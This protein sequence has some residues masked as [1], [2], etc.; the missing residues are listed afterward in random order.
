MLGL[1][2]IAKI[3]EIMR[4]GQLQGVTYLD[5]SDNELSSKITSEFIILLKAVP[6]SVKTLDLSCN[7]LN[8]FKSDELVEL[9]Q[10][11]PHSV[12]FLILKDN[13]FYKKTNTDLAKI[14]QAI[15][16]NVISLD[17]R[18]NKLLVDKT[19]LLQIIYVV[20]PKVQLIITE[21]YPINIKHSYI[22]G[23]SPRFHLFNA[24]HEHY[25]LKGDKLKKYILD[26][27]LLQVNQCDT[28]ETLT[29]VITHFKNM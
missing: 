7:G 19:K 29:Q 18:D 8:Y 9:F 28:K 10:A 26:V 11:I 4:S 27:F 6:A 2:S 1:M 25:N 20:P 5:I 14:Y 21:Y 22:Y 23:E 12:E 3:I 17:L 24:H 15:P 13:D 16:K